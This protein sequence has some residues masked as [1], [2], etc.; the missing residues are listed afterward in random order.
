MNI[1][2]N[3][4]WLKKIDLLGKLSIAN[5]IRSLLQ[6]QTSVLCIFTLVACLNINY[7]Q[8]NSFQSVVFGCYSENIEEFEQFAIEA[9]EAGA[10]HVQVNAEDLPLA[11]W[12]MQPAGD[13]YPAWVI[14][15]PGLLKT[16]I[17]DALV[18]YLPEALDVAGRVS[19]ILQERCKVLRKYN[20]KAAFHTFEP[21]MLPE[22]VYEDHP[23]WR[24]PQVDHPMRSRTARFAPAIDNPEVLKLY[25]EAVKKFISVCPEVN[26]IYFRT[27]DSGAGLDWSP[28]LY[29]GSNGNSN[30]KHISMGERVKGFLSAIQKGAEEAGSSVAVNVYNAVEGEARE[31]AKGL[32]KNMAIDGFEG[33]GANQFK[34]DVDNLLNYSRA[35]SPIVGIPRPLYFIERLQKTYNS[36]TPRLFV[37]IADRQNKDLYLK[38]Y[39]E[40]QKSPTTGLIENLQLL[41]RV[42]EGLVGK[43]N[44]PNLFDMWVALD[45]ARKIVSLTNAGG[46]IFNLGSVQQRWLV[47]PLVPFPSKLKADEKDY[48]RKHQFQAQ[49]EKEAEY[50]LD[51]QGM[52]VY[53]GQG[54]K[55]YIQKVIH[56]PG[57]SNN[58]RTAINRA[59]ALSRGLS[60]KVNG[61]LKKSFELLTARLT[62]YSYLMNNVFNVV[63]YQ[64]QL[65]RINYSES[66]SG[67]V[68]MGSSSSAGRSKMLQVVRNEIDNTSNL[69]ALLESQEKMSDIIVHAKTNEEEYIRLFGPGLIEQLKK[70]IKI[71]NGHWRDYNEIFSRP[72]L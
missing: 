56:D 26:I 40:F 60:I 8:N 35:F 68:A 19:T 65:E 70:K 6:R 66:K 61:E 71:M 39:K 3:N 1:S 42:A 25:T 41:M 37:A 49:S 58:V 15:N 53:T 30:Y 38:I 64:T 59:I 2:L 46:T 43:E 62:A 12:Q 36:N 24:G 10:T 29:N 54:G 20:L 72:N 33:P 51:L 7:A 50:L 18:K 28:Q 47:R 31:I 69:I 44:A 5:C 14:S 55:R 57:V 48:Y 23:L 22:S 67:N 27:N 4:S 13:P 16:F 11:Y 17:P 32:D 9:K 52:R 63:S 21:Q 45:E 34:A